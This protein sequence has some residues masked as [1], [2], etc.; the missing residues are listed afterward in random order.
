[1]TAEEKLM[2]ERSREG[3]LKEQ[4]KRDYQKKIFDG[5]VIYVN[6]STYPLVGVHKLK[7]LLAENGAKLAL[8]LGRKTVTHVIL[9]KQSGSQGT[10]AGGGLAGTKIE[11]EIRRV[12][13]CGVKYV[14]VE[15]LVAQT[16]IR[17]NDSVSDLYRV[18]ESVKAGRRLPEAS[19]TNLK[20]AAKRQQ[21]VYGMFQKKSSSTKSSD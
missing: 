11:R 12:G 8:H 13:G 19:F 10:G 9:G 15:W 3:E 6:G 5:L 1:M 4:E 18:L 16:R 21:S 14:D 17:D 20:V 2:A 7:M